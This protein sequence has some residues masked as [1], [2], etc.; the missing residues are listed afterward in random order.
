MN[1]GNKKKLY[2]FLGIAL[3]VVLLTGCTQ[4]FCSNIDKANI[5]YTYDMGVT[6][7]VDNVESIPEAF[8][9]S[10]N[11]KYWTVK[12]NGSDSGVFAYIP[13]GTETVEKND[14]TKR[15]TTRYTAKKAEFLDSIIA[16][17]VSNNYAVP[18]YSYFKAMDEKLL[19]TAIEEKNKD[20]APADQITASNLT[21]AM[22][23]VF[24]DPDTL[25]KADGSDINY[26]S[27][28]LNYGYVKFSGVVGTDGVRSDELW[29][30]WDAWNEEIAAEIGEDQVPQN[31]F[32]NLYKNQINAKLANARSCISTKPGYFGHYGNSSNIS[33]NVTQ[34][35]WKDAWKKG[36]FEG[37]IVYPVASLID[38]IAYGIDPQLSGL[39]QVLSILIVTVI[40]RLLILAAT[41]KSTLDQ[42][43]TQA[44]QPQLAKI[45]A[46]Y[47]NSNTNK[48]EAQRLQQE[49]MALY[50]RNKINPLSMLITLV[51]QF[52]VF[53][54]VWG[55]MQGSSVLASGSILNL[56][57]SDTISSVLTNFSK[58]WATNA[59]G[60]WTAAILFIA[61]AVFQIGAMMIPQWINKKKLKSIPKTSANPAQDKN[62][63]SMKMMSWFM[64][65]FTIIMG[66]ALP[67]AMGLY[68]AVGAL[69][70]LAQTLITQSIMAKKNK[71]AR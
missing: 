8:K 22:I 40:V 38:V 66:F 1:K 65:I 55:A 59:T 33:A 13:V 27:I 7:Y 10:G 49:Q 9:E 32:A 60:W 4:N 3:G 51:V 5:A 68:W 6:V 28:L 52:P 18:S 11:E 16:T 39:G 45:Q 26:E 43:R 23:N 34:K 50:K 70:S 64:V 24:S 36:F 56:R 67:A 53:I 29:G 62:G 31:D 71:K 46:K 15:I 20:L 61:M 21:A 12:L 41:F 35:T 69:I 30:Q 37:L 42:Q 14:S 44:L 63:S 2:S 47:P 57:L 58:G 54:C 25:G 17:A 19:A 48:D